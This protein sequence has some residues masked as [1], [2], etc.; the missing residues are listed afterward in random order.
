M[1]VAAS[2]SLIGMPT[3]PSTRE[4]KQAIK[5]IKFLSKLE[6]S[7]F[8]YLKYMDN[9]NH[10]YSYRILTDIILLYCEMTVAF[11]TAGMLIFSGFIYCLT[12]IHVSK[13][14]VFLFM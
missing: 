13:M 9:Y 10:I 5:L 8:S 12:R 7:N 6:I 2:V 4:H 3:Y 14:L 11:I 1:Y